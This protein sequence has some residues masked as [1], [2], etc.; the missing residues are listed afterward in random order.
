MSLSARLASTLSALLLLSCA[1]SPPEPPE[2]PAERRVPEPPPEVQVQIE[3]PPASAL[4]PVPWR[5]PR[6]RLQ[7]NVR[8]PEA[9][10]RY[11]RRHSGSGSGIER[12]RDRLQGAWSF[13]YG[14]TVGMAIFEPSG[15]LVLQALDGDKVALTFRVLRAPGATGSEPGHLQLRTAPDSS[16]PGPSTGHDA[17]DLR[18]RFRALFK[19]RSTGQVDLQV[20][21]AGEDWPEEFGADRYRLFRDVEEALRFLGR[22]QRRWSDVPDARRAGYESR[23]GGRP[24]PAGPGDPAESRTPLIAGAP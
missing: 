14:G 5:Q 1:S 6:P 3:S 24:G 17:G 19:W 20:P 2:S 13:V 10:V 21:A 16:A 4:A 18:L 8:A 12:A 23:P 11:R 7:L 9:A 15:R 22:S